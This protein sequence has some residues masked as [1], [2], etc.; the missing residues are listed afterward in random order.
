MTTPAPTP[1]TSVYLIAARVRVAALRE[2]LKSTAPA[3]APGTY[4]RQSREQ[5]LA[6]DEQRLARLEQ[7][8]V[9][10]N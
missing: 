2:E 7:L 5:E 4:W 10:L 9:A 3:H 1:T 6:L 8:E